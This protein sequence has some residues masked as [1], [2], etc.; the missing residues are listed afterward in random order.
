M[1]APMVAPSFPFQMRA[2]S[3]SETDLPSPAPDDP[4]SAKTPQAD[5]GSLTSPDDRDEVFDEPINGVDEIALDHLVGKFLYSEAQHCF[6]SQLTGFRDGMAVRVSS[7][8]R[9]PSPLVQHGLYY[10]RSLGNNPEW[11]GLAPTPDGEPIHIYSPGSGDH[12]IRAILKFRTFSFGGFRKAGK[13]L[14]L[15][16]ILGSMEDVENA[17]AEVLIS[18]ALTI[19]WMQCSPPDEVSKVFRDL[20]HDEHA[21][22]DAV[23]D[24]E[25]K[26]VA[27]DE[28]VIRAILRQTLYVVTLAKK[29]WFNIIARERPGSKVPEDLPGNS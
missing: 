10:L 19:A 23:E 4:A 14:G 15:N 22:E 26:V 6:V 18:E 17:D 20:R 5:L 1:P 11:F 13:R 8:D 28:E 7:S 12:F 16:I 3:M 9:L 29:T 25:E 2:L 27:F 21:V 24:F